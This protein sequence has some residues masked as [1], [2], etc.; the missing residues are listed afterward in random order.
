MG[1]EGVLVDHFDPAQ[2][3]CTVR[4]AFGRVEFQHLS[5]YAH[6]LRK[7]LRQYAEEARFELARAAIEHHKA[8]SHL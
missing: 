8:G 3:W 7:A 4:P 1:N 2:H 6:E 5:V